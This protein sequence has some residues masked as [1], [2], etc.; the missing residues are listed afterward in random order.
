MNNHLRED[1]SSHFGAMHRR[2]AL[3]ENPVGSADNQ[4]LID[5]RIADIERRQQTFEEDINKKITA[6]TAN[7]R[8]KDISIGA[9]SGGAAASGDASDFFTVCEGVI[10]VL[11]REVEKLTTQV[12][13]SCF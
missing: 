6:A 11:N 4:N 1:L 8:M 3:I 5:S 2:L 10:T 7:Q 13:L 12:C 9:A